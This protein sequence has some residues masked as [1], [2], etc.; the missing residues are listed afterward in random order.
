MPSDSGK[1]IPNK[2]LTTKETKSRGL[3]TPF[4][5]LFKERFSMKL[6][7]LKLQVLSPVQAFPRSAVRQSII[8]SYVLGKL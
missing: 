6:A 7:K 8:L 2:E 5:G 3:R 4:I 1:Q